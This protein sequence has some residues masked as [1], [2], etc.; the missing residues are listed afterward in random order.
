MNSKESFLYDQAI[1]LR[2]EILTY[3]L[4]PRRKAA[5]DALKPVRQDLYYA[6]LAVMY[7]VWPMKITG[8]GITA[9]APA[10]EI[11]KYFI[12]YDA[13][14]FEDAP[15]VP[16]ATTPEKSFEVGCATLGLEAFFERECVAGQAMPRRCFIV[17]PQ[18]LEEQ[19]ARVARQARQYERMNPTEL[20]LKAGEEQGEFATAVLVETGAIT[21]KTLK[22]PSFGEAA[23]V[24][25]CHM[26]ALAKLYP[27]MTDEE[28]AAE[29]TRWIHIKQ[30]KYDQLLESKRLDS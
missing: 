19:L 5:L 15:T 29:L 2:D 20:A 4:G 24:L 25:L 11:G 12:S 26:S 18:P 16:L 9:S 28:I 22:E 6:V 10:H 1:A 23:D 14:D 8:D 17:P 13:C 3:P 7:N 27:R 21:H 30:A